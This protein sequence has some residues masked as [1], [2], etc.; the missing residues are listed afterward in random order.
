MEK[1]IFGRTGE[2]SMLDN[3]IEAV[4]HGG[5]SFIWVDGVP[6]S[7]KSTLLSEAVRR[8]AH[9]GVETRVARC[10]ELGG[11]PYGPIN[12]MIDLAIPQEMA[13]DRWYVSVRFEQAL[14]SLTAADRPVG[15]FIDDVQW[16]DYGT[17]AFLSHCHTSTAASLFVCVFSRPLDQSGPCPEV[18]DLARQVY[19][20]GGIRLKLHNL[21][22]AETSQV[23]ESLVARATSE[24][25]VDEVL[26]E[27]G[28]HP[29]TVVQ[30]CRAWAES[31]KSI[32]DFKRSDSDH[33]LPREIGSLFRTRINLLSNEVRII[34]ESLSVFT[35]PVVP[36]WIASMNGME[37]IAAINAINTLCR[38]GFVTEVDSGSFVSH[39]L[40]RRTVVGDLG[41]HT[42]TAYH[43]AAAEVLSCLQEVS[44]FELARHYEGCGDHLGAFHSLWKAGEHCR[45]HLDHFQVSDYLLR[46]ERHLS[47]TQEVSNTDIQ[48][49]RIDR[50]RSEMVMGNFGFCRQVVRELKDI[51]LSRPLKSKLIDLE[52]RLLRREAKYSEAAILFIESLQYCSDES[53]RAANLMLLASAR[54]GEGRVEEA[55]IALRE[56]ADLLESVGSE[57]G[58]HRAVTTKIY[59]AFLERRFVDAVNLG[60]ENELRRGQITLI[61][62]AFYAGDYQYCR[63]YCQQSVGQAPGSYHLQYYLGSIEANAGNYTEALR[64]LK[65]TLACR[66]GRVEKLRIWC[67]SLA[68]ECQ[69][70][71]GQVRQFKD[72][73][74][75]LEKL[76]VP[77]GES[78]LV[79]ARA[80]A[81]AYEA[82]GKGGTA[83]KA[84]NESIDCPIPR[85]SGQWAVSVVE[86]VAFLLRV[87][88]SLG[89]RRTAEEAAL[90]LDRMQIPSI[91]EKL[92]TL[93]LDSDFDLAGEQLSVPADLIGKLAQTQTPADLVSSVCNELAI[94]LNAIEVRVK[95]ISPGPY[96]SATQLP[97]YVHSLSSVGNRYEVEVIGTDH[98]DSDLGKTHVT[99]LLNILGIVLGGRGLGDL[100]TELPEPKI[101]HGLVGGSTAM[102][103]VA[104]EIDIAGSCDESVLILGETGTGKDLV[105]R[106]I[107]KVSER[108]EKP[109][110]SV[111]CAA[112]SEELL[113]SELFGHRRGSFT[114]ADSDRKGLFESAS[115]GVLFLD[116]IGEASSLVQASL[117]RVLQNR[118][119]RRVGD[120]S[121]RPVDVRIIA[122]TNRDLDNE[123]AAKSFRTDLLYRLKVLQIKMPPLRAR[124]E[125]IPALV[126]YFV[127]SLDTTTGR[128]IAGIASGTME[129]LRSLNWP[130]NVRELENWVRAMYFRTDPGELLYLVEPKKPD[131]Q[132]SSLKDRIGQLEKEAIVETLAIVRGNVSNAARRLGMSRSGLQKKMLKHRIRKA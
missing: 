79:V 17:A 31:G 92:R 104:A 82:L 6:G 30:Y 107:H 4:S 93:M 75:S 117:L 116:E 72:L 77:E 65:P 127:S 98:K 108:R 86:Y 61:R 99:T 8:C 10:L 91:K 33:L 110:L 29:L 16:A 5:K 1:R 39:G 96:H 119:I 67:I 125:D 71:L 28:G 103:S 118:T 32:D 36:S 27:T 126:Q 12:T 22:R 106:A 60:R 23:V 19:V 102:R 83:S 78:R 132:V 46:A 49:F 3:Q 68:L 48:S 63:E 70:A 13:H 85:R 84:F 94:S 59:V 62:S 18:E 54:E 97:S 55:I 37:E 41:L 50:A 95:G 43:K 25:E 44:V 124:L 7:G 112:L 69:V 87:G 9:W 66:S 115:G 128:S 76:E 114:G 51:V 121:E 53:S 101:D 129:H 24:R 73:L 131:I 38:K 42:R 88:D 20:R 80:R 120:N 122:A 81:K 52:A 111:N 89:A 45:G 56:A 58:L 21:D 15:I 47:L 123:S 64:I 2:L 109:Y 40:L 11:D 14:R 74:R 113:L 35:C 57:S 100:C 130:G 90:D 34:L 105:A 26:D